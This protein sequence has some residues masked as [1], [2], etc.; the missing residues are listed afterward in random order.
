MWCTYKTSCGLE[1]APTTVICFCVQLL[2]FLLVFLFLIVVLL[3]RIRVLLADL[4]R[5]WLSTVIDS[6]GKK[7]GTTRESEQKNEKS[8]Y[9]RK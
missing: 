3:F 7:D 9:V 4:C 2:R 5:F 1:A 6:P 8:E